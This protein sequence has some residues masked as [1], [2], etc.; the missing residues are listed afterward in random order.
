MGK[1]KKVS[2]KEF[3]EFISNYPTKLKS[4]CT[5]ICDP[6]FRSFRDEILPTNGVIG[7]IDYYFDKEIA[8]I[9]MDYGPIGGF[10]H[11][12]HFLSVCWHSLHVLG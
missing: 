7:D 4:G 3:G 1:L 8:R 2:K 6:P 12:I 10:S 9:V 11:L 5:H